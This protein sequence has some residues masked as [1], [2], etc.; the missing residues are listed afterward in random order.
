[1][2]PKILVVDDERVIAKTLSIILNQSGFEAIAAYSGAEALEIA[3][4]FRPDMV[5]I[6]VV[7]AGM[8]GIEAAIHIREMLPSCRVVLL[9]G[10]PAAADFLDEARE[11]GHEFDIVAKPL[12]PN[13]LIAYLRGETELKDS[14]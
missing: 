6:D 14:A 3:H 12:H 4:S 8:N 9:S 7:M 1:M 5:V 11:Q 10:Q 2:K 13:K